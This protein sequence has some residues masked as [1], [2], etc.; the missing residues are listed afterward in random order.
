MTLGLDVDV[1]PE[2]EDD[3]DDGDFFAGSA[4]PGPRDPRDI[5]VL[6]CHCAALRVHDLCQLTVTPS[7]AVLGVS[8]A[9][10][11]SAMRLS[12]ITDDE[13]ES[14]ARAVRVMASVQASIL[15]LRA[16]RSVDQQ[17]ARRR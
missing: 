15:N 9:E 10:I 1:G 6:E 12:G 3:E 5:H 13:R 14:V 2:T 16:R 7:G 11:E 8:A 4:E 17:R